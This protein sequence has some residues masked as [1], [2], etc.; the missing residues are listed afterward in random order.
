MHS[1]PPAPPPPTA[2]STGSLEEPVLRG[3]GGRLWGGGVRWG[4]VPCL[5]GICPPDTPCC[6]HS[7][8]RCSTSL[9]G[10]GRRAPAWWGSCGHG[11]AR[12]AGRLSGGT[13]ETR[14]VCPAGLA[15]LGQ[16]CHLCGSRK[17]PLGESVVW[18]VSL[19]PK[20]HTGPNGCPCV[21][22][23]PFPQAASRDFGLASREVKRPPPGTNTSVTNHSCQFLTA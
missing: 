4:G 13:T 12:G 16:V 2:Q 5:S 22:G 18:S 7:G 10:C 9:F 23:A 1:W 15:D 11:G 8:A 6:S 21:L 3:A 14:H 19:C 20:A 17:T